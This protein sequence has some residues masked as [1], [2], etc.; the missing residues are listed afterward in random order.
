MRFE[1]K[2]LKLK[3]LKKNTVTV[4]AAL[5]VDH[6]FEGVYGLTRHIKCVIDDKSP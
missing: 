2:N 1:K 3:F 4:K 5:S 6:R